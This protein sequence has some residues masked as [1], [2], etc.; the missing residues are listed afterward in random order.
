[1]IFIC[2]KRPKYQ[3]N[4]AKRKIIT[5]RDGRTKV[6]SYFLNFIHDFF[7]ERRLRESL[8]KITWDAQSNLGSC[9][10]HS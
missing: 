2:E 6:N 1:M 9:F 5:N 10:P 4:M 7:S 3:H 8:K